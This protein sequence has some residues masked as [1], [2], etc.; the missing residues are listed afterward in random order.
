VIDEL[1]YISALRALRKVKG[2]SWVLFMYVV[3][4]HLSWSIIILI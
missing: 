1:L 2:D 4:D 3:Y